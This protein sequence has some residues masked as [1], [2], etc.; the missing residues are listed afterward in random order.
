MEDF[1]AEVEA[2]AHAWPANRPDLHW[3]IL[4]DPAVVEEKLVGPYRELTHR[5]GLAPVEARWVHTTVMHGG[6]VA[7]YKDEELDTI[8]ELVRQECATIA[9]FDLTFDRPAIGRVAVE[10]AARP[11]APARRLWQL[12]TQIDV[13]VTGGR[14]PV[15]P[16]GYY[17]HQSLAYGMAGEV[18]A[19]RRAMKVLMSDHPGEPVT[20][21]ADK[22]SL[23]AQAHDRQFITWEHIVDVPLLGGGQ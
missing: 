1:Y 17:P 6:P 23:V 8:V 10:C 5:P 3:H 18:R 13:D 22:L 9:P 7:D 2:R 16:A 20:L 15:M 14:N 21:R 12:T 19:D 11:G 4:F